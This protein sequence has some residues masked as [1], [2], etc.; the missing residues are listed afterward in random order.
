M[1]ATRK[2]LPEQ[3]AGLR[4]ELEKGLRVIGEFAS[5]GTTLTVVG[6]ENDYDCCRYF[7][8]DGKMVVSLDKRHVGMPE[9][10]AWLWKYAKQQDAT[11]TA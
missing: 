2:P 10:L 1:A 6:G 11:P 4:A 3:L 8:L 5:N 9:V 7:P